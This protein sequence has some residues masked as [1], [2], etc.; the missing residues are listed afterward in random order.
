MI[1]CDLGSNTLRIV[2]IDCKTKKRVIEFEKIVKTGQNLKNSGKISDESI[3]NIFDAL[4]EASS[5]FDFSSKKT[6][7][8]TTEAM[9]LASNSDEILKTIKERFNLDFQIICGDTEAQYT[10]QGVKNSLRLLNIP[11]D[12]FCMFDLGGGSTE[13]IYVQ[14][15]NTSYKS[16]PFGILKISEQYPDLESL[17][18]GIYEEIEQINY[19]I[20]GHN[21][22]KKLIATAGTPTT[23]CAFLQDVD[24]R[25]YNHNKVSGK[26]LHINDFKKAYTQ[27]LA[28]SLE[29]Q[30]RYCGTNRSEL[31]KTGILIIIG[32]MEKLKFEECLIVDDGLREGVALS[33]CNFG[34]V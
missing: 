21:K 1:G 31:I 10:L 14:E 28:L 20:K 23:V 29:E 30:E 17:Q 27:I 6:K 7:C 18:N 2:E 9:R 12:D 8:V 34:F 11:D 5:I 4:E 26:I 33:L 15:N 3:K 25:S 22:P 24:Y 32:L 16:F 19:F 13:I